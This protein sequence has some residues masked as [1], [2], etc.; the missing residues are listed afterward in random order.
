MTIV[1]YRRRAQNPANGG[2]ETRRAFT[3]SVFS[4]KP[5]DLGL[6]DKFAVFNSEED[7][8]AE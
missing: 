2:P 6:L 5:L 8:Q 3:A 4:M 1:Y 7:R